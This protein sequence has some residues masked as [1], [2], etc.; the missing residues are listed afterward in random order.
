MPASFGVLIVFEIAPEMK[1]CAAHH[2]DVAFDA[3]K[4]LPVRPQGLRN[5]RRRNVPASDAARLRASWRR[6][7][8]YCGLDLG[9]GEPQKAQN[10][11]ILILQPFRRNLEDAGAK[12]RAKRPF[13]EDEFDV[14]GGAEQSSISSSFG[15]VKPFAFR[16][17]GLIAGAFCSEPCPVA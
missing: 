15:C 17:A 4:R 10:I 13:V 11:E 6:R 8:K 16:L 12:L 14:E 1:G 7:R 5:R 9:A 2:A 3:K